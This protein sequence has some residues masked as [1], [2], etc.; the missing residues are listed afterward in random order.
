MYQA[1]SHLFNFPKL[2]SLAGLK[3]SPLSP[4]TLEVSIASA[5]DSSDR[6]PLR[7]DPCPQRNV[8][9]NFDEH[10]SD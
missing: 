2:D 9:L 7:T 4:E 10:S 1:T 5:L 6:K 8:P 3:Y